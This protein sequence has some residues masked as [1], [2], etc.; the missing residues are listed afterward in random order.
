MKYNVQKLQAGGGLATFNPILSRLSNPAADKTSQQPE[1]ESGVKSSLID[2]EVYK[3]LLE[4]G[5]YSDTKK[6]IRE[7][8]EIENGSENPFNIE[9]NRMSTLK[10]YEKLSQLRRNKI[11]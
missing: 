1:G 2:K 7:L 10:V 11:N 9:G 4:N 6:V 5:L 3:E 8:S